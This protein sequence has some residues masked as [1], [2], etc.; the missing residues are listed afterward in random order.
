MKFPEIYFTSKAYLW[1]TVL[2][3][4]Y[5]LGYFFSELFYFANFTFALILFAII[6]DYILLFGK[7]ASVE[8]IRICPTR[9]SN[10]DENPIE[11]KIINHYRFKIGLCIVDELPFQFQSRDFEKKMTLEAYKTLSFMYYL[12]PVKRGEYWFGKLRVF[13]KSPLEL[14]ERRFSLEKEKMLPVFPSF[15]QMRKYALL[16][17][18]NRLVQGGIKKIRKIGSSTDFDQIKEYVSGDEIKTVNWKATARKGRLMVNKYQ[19]EKSQ[20]VY[21]V[22]DLGR[23]MQ[24]PFEGMSLLDYAINAALVISNIASVKGDRPG[25][26]SYSHKIH[27]MLRA[28]KRNTQMNHIM[29]ALYNQHTDFTESDA[30]TLFLQ[31]RKTISQRSL[32]LL[33]TNFETVSGL[34]RQLPYLR[35]LA[36]NHLLVVIFFENTELLKLQNEKAKDTYDIYYKTIAGKFALEKQLIAMELSACGI[37]SL[38]THPAGLSVNIINKYLELKS[39]KLI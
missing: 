1:V 22:L 34:K 17:I 15:I 18:H 16:A 19:D 33:F 5:G 30:G 35:K 27:T 38:F 10:G 6:L 11:I 25:L 2:I 28:E 26:I 21:C 31:V 7:H 39:R 12:R 8:G 23:T 20:Q 14:T 32:L 4:I 3:F 9:L 36:V 13:A 29:E 24:M 37:Q